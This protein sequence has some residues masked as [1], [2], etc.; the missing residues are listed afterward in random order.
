MTARMEAFCSEFAEIEQRLRSKGVCVGKRIAISPP[1]A[2]YAAII[3]LNDYN[4]QSDV[5][6][7]EIQAS[8]KK[9]K[10]HKPK[11]LRKGES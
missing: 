2:E 4:T 8:A 5:A 10:E 3:N 11:V 9:K 6:I 1:T 7:T